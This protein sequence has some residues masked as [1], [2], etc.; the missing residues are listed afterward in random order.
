M[1]RESNYKIIGHCAD[2]LMRWNFASVLAVVVILSCNEINSDNVPVTIKDV[3][4]RLLTSLQQDVP[5]VWAYKDT[6]RHRKELM[7]DQGLIDRS[8]RHLS[9]RNRLKQLLSLAEQGFGID[10]SVVGGSISRGQPFVQKGQGKRVYHNA[11]KDWWNKVVQPITGSKMTIRDVSIG[12][13]G[14]EYFANCLPVHLAKE[15][16][17]NLILWELSGNDVARYSGVA[18]N[19]SQPLEQ[20][21]RNTLRYRSQPEIL[22]LNFF[23]GNDFLSKRGCH[24]LDMEGET[25]VAQYYDVTELSW[26]KSVCPYLMRDESGMAFEYLF[27]ND[28]Y[29]PSIAAHAQMAYILIDHIRDQ[30][31]KAITSGT[32]QKNIPIK[33]TLPVPI[34]SQTYTGAPL[35]YSL[36]KVDK[37]EPLNTLQ[38]DIVSSPKYSLSTY[39]SFVH[40]GDKLQGLQ[41]KSANEI[42]T[43]RFVIPSYAAVLPFKKLTVLSFARSGEAVSQLD[44]REAVP[45]QTN[46]YS[47]LGTT[48]SAAASN[49]GPGEHQ[50]RIW[51]KRGGFLVMALML[52]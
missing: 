51:S 45:L 17:T 16:N 33:S 2:F 24:D 1:S 43:F 32:L 19:V 40:R 26:T 3:E 25:P 38:V 31:V 30:F 10:V 20:F 11:L 18:S 49:I 12:G 23:N 52:T 14:S 48:E 35:C 4:Q 29:H 22:L 5:S 37:D 9:K 47:S 28:H 46:K 7:L 44:K 41:T 13:V 27:S 15:S 21:L 34:F 8:K 50:L 42:I 6:F 39:R 36:L